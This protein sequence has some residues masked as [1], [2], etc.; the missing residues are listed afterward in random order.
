MMMAEIVALQRA[1]FR[2]R[3]RPTR[4]PYSSPQMINH[5]SKL[6]MEG[7]IA[8]RSM[9]MRDFPS[10]TPFLSLLRSKTN[11]PRP[12]IKL[13]CAQI[14]LFHSLPKAH[15]FSLMYQILRY[16]DFAPAS[17]ASSN[18]NFDMRHIISLILSF[19]LSVRIFGG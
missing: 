18:Q 14:I 19:K 10:T 13:T 4:R 8:T 3:F 12:I 11:C 5:R 2:A 16:Y 15:L 17:S 1:I 9:R 6:P 7:A